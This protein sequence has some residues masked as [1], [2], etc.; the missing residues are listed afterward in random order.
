MLDIILVTDHL[1]MRSQ[2][3]YADWG[4]ANCFDAESLP[5]F[6]E[7]YEIY[8]YSGCVT[9]CKALFVI[10]KCGCKEIDQPGESANF[11]NLICLQASVCRSCH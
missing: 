1:K 9:E 11:N 3:P 8:S 10:A 7:F 2:P 5:N 4:K 6:L